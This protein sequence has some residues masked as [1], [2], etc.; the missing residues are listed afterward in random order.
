MTNQK[1]QKHPAMKTTFR[2]LLIFIC[3]QM[4]AVTRAYGFVSASR[5]VLNF[6]ETSQV[7]ITIPQIDNADLYLATEFNGKLW[8]IQGEGLGLTLNALPFR[9]KVQAGTT[10]TLLLNAQSIFPG[11]YP[12][13]A[14]VVKTGEDVF[15]KEH[16]LD[17]L[18]RINFFIGVSDLV[19]NDSNGDGFPDDDLNRDGFSDADLDFDGKVDTCAAVP[20]NNANQSKTTHC[21]QVLGA[22]LYQR[23]SCASGSCH[24]NNPA[25]NSNGVL[26]G[27][28]VAEIRLASKRNPEDMGNLNLKS[29]YELQA[30]AEYLTTYAGSGFT[31]DW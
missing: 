24:G 7:N 1:M 27:Q 3:I 16:W 17:D 26:R 2:T 30:I 4:I 21:H 19:S 6:A 25:A 22:K 15:R 5:T 11:R 13:Y 8:F 12:L 31:W 29:D 9:S 20:D 10:Y 28:T 23:F 14:L 18:Q